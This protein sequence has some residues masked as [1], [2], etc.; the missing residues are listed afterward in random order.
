MGLHQ[1]RQAYLD[2]IYN[3]HYPR[4][5]VTGETRRSQ[6]NLRRSSSATR[7]T[8]TNVFERL[9]EAQKWI[10]Q[11]TEELNG[12]RFLENLQVMEEMFEKHKL[13]N[14]DIQDFRRSAVDE[15]IAR[16]VRSFS[17][18]EVTPC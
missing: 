5:G 18:L 17:K 13:D 16:Q 7:T 2:R 1:R 3:V 8:R 4:F 12:M 9:L 10:D 14:R 11:K 6:T 15:C